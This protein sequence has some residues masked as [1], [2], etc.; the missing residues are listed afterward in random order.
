M[1]FESGKDAAFMAGSVEGPSQSGAW[2]HLFEVEISDIHPSIHF[3]L[4][5]LCEGSFHNRTGRFCERIE[6]KR[7]VT[8]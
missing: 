6:I 4:I 7:Q 5:G 3:A 1:K 8:S 2:G